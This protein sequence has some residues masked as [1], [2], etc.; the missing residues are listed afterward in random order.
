M[1]AGL[2]K[3]FNTFK[4]AF[5]PLIDLVDMNH[6]SV[7]GTSMSG[8]RGA[9]TRPQVWKQNLGYGHQIRG[10]TWGGLVPQETKSWTY[11]PGI[12]NLI[13]FA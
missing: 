11:N 4:I 2:I 5:M 3:Y 7:A 13:L 8:G 9:W 12:E 10:K 1:I 6:G